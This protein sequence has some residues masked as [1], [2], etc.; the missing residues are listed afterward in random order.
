MLRRIGFG[1]RASKTFDVVVLFMAFVAAVQLFFWTDYNAPV[2]IH[3]R[4]FRDL[5][6]PPGGMLVYE[7]NFTRYR[8][9][10]TTVDRWFIGSDNVIR[11]IESL[12]SALPTDG[13]NR[14]Q[15]AEAK[16]MVPRDMPYGLAK[17]CFRP[18]WICSQPNPIQSV[19]PIYGDETCFDFLV[20]PWAGKGVARATTPF[21]LSVDF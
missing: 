16:I 17:F 5:S 12:P 14:R 13:L 9:C 18:H 4:V 19:A 15:T 21:V 7:N 1:D 8:Y 20:V 6:L 3:F 10:D 2:K 11:R